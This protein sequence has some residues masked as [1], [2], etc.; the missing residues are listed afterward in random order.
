MIHNRSAPVGAVA[1]RLVYED[2]AA[3]IEWLCRAFGFAER[4]RYGRDGTVEGALLAVGEGGV[5]ISGP[6]VGHGSAERFEFR[7]PRPDESSHSLVVQV[8]DVD[9]HHEQ[10]R[11]SGARILLSPT[12]YPFGERQYTAQD[13]A[14]RLWTFSQSVADVAPEEWGAAP[15]S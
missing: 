12:T 13:F 2:P 5:M 8:E 1:P 9:R 14:G 6:R 3:A 10:A 7:P 15:A 11:L 4:Y